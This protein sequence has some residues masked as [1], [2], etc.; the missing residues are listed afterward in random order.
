RV[1][2]DWDSTDHSVTDMAGVPAYMKERVSPT[3]PSPRASIPIPVLHA[4]SVTR[5]A[6]NLRPK[7]SAM[8]RNPAPPAGSGWQRTRAGWLTRLVTPGTTPWQEKTTYR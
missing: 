7:V 6:L 3:T 8:V 5:S 4:E 1:F 2:A